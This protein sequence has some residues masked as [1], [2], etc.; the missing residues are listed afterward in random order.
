MI[1]AS[2][3]PQTLVTSGNPVLFHLSSTQWNQPNHF[4]SCR[5]EINGSAG[6]RIINLI[7]FIFSSANQSP[8]AIINMQRLLE[9]YLQEIPYPLPVF[10]GAP[11]QL[12]DITT[13]LTCSFHVEHSQTY[14]DP[15]VAQPSVLRWP[16]SGSALCWRGGFAYPQFPPLSY[17]HD[18]M[19][20]SLGNSPFLTWKPLSSL[21]GPSQHEFLTFLNFDSGKNKLR[22][23]FEITY[24]DGSTQD[25]YFAD[26]SSG[27]GKIHRVNVGLAALDLANLDPYRTIAYYEVWLSN[28]G[29]R[30]SEKRRYVVDYKSYPATRYLLFVNSL[31]GLD[32]VRFVG[33]GE[34][35]ADYKRE[36]T[37]LYQGRYDPRY[38]DMRTVYAVESA[39]GKI[40]TGYIS[41]AEVQ[42]LR[43]LFLS[44]QV[45][46]LEGNR[47]L[48]ITVS[49][50][51][52]SLPEEAD[53]NAL[54]VDYDFQFENERYTPAYQS[55]N[56]IP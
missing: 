55:I 50:K 39:G 34:F 51:K 17:A 13:S 8:Q 54:S 14:G 41:R 32:T 27:K 40:N 47:L 7:D 28:S 46:L 4:L 49:G 48:P 19:M 43:D 42:W 22:L 31:G 35:T 53:V 25:G 37:D 10:T 23:D 36:T 52:L 2:H 18:W 44:R 15:P 26:Y 21:M 30:A 20:Q 33:S 16:S 1:T 24:V 11:G 38:G 29:N 9:D 6:Q 56:F 12:T 45:F 3:T 5:V